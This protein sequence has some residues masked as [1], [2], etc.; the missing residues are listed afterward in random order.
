MPDFL[1]EVGL[2]EIPARMIAAAQAELAERV[3]NLLTRENLVAAEST[4]DS[5]STPR[6]LAVR[7]TAVLNEQ[8]N[9]EELVTG[10]ASSIA[11][12]NGEAM[13]SAHAFARKAGVEVSALTR[14]NTPKGEYV[15][16]RV[17][18]KGQSAVAV[19]KTKLPKELAAI[20]WPKNMYWRAGK[21]ERFVRPLR[22][23]LG[24][25]DDQ[26]V[27]VEFAGTVASNKTYGH[28]ILHSDQPIE[29]GN[30]S[31]YLQKLEAGFVIADVEGRRHRIRKALDAAARTVSGL[32]WREDHPLVDA[33]THLHRNGLSVLLS[34]SFEAEYLTASRRGPCDR[35][36]RAPSEILRSGGWTWQARAVL[37]GR[38]EYRSE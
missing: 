15:T 8:P 18:H 14:T 31:E 9:L 11:F 20:Y 17:L 28:R 21:P 24:L 5:Y 2:E 29:I 38:S 1:F 25:L 16:A 26:V 32:R 30:P 7:V 36:V 10:P 19:L 37:S 33:V 22:W 13:P 4:V 27:D 3:H 12:R 6:R 35:D 23:L 34:G